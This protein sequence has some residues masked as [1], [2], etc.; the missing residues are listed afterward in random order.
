MRLCSDVGAILILFVLYLLRAHLFYCGCCGSIPNQ[1]S[2]VFLRIMC[3]CLDS[4]H[5]NEFKLQFC[6]AG[7][8]YSWAYQSWMFQLPLLGHSTVA[9]SSTCAFVLLR[10]LWFYSQWVVLVLW[11]GGDKERNGDLGGLRQNT[12]TPKITRKNHT[13]KERIDSRWCSQWVVLVLCVCSGHRFQGV[14]LSHA[15]PIA[16]SSPR[17][18]PLHTLRLIVLPLRSPVTAGLAGEIS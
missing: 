3:E 9:V 16:R 17:W 12:V 14:G 4:K 1:L 8:M 18:H 13:P 5:L 6:T 2:C 11:W 15:I 7:S 10:L